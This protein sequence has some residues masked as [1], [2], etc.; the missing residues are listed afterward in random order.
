MCQVPHPKGRKV[1]SMPEPGAVPP[2]NLLNH[3]DPNGSG[4]NNK[5]KDKDDPANDHKDNKDVN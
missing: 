3:H 4:N 5:D 2:D 1:A